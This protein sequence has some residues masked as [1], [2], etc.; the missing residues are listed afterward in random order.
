MLFSFSYFTCMKQHV[1]GRVSLSADHEV[2]LETLEHQL[3]R[4][5]HDAVSHVGNLFGG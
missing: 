5:I 3:I 1:S 2:R 4:L